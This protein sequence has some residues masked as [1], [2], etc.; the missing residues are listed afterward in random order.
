MRPATRLQYGEFNFSEG[1]ASDR[2]GGYEDALRTGAD[3]FNTGHVY[4]IPTTGV[5]GV[6]PGDNGILFRQGQY[7]GVLRATLAPSGITP[8]QTYLARQSSGWPGDTPL[9]LQAQ[10]RRPA[11]W[12]KG[13]PLLLGDRSQ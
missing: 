11:P 3:E 9:D 2:W 8:G 5:G 4:D 12:R 7:L 13:T 6:R 1:G 10:V